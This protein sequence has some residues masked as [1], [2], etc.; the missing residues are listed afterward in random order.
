MANR[1]VPGTG[2][3]LAVAIETNG[4]SVGDDGAAQLA[5][6]ASGNV[7][8]VWNLTTSTSTSVWAN[9]FV[10]GTGWGTA[11]QIGSGN[12][13]S[14]GVNAQVGVDAAGNGFAV[15]QQYNG[16][17][18]NIWGNQFVAGTG[19][20][21]AALIQ[22]D[23]TLSS[24]DPRVAL[25]STGHAMVVWAQF[26]LVTSKDHIWASYFSAGSGWG[27][28]TLLQASNPT[29]QSNLP[30]IAFDPAGN[31]IA[32]W[33]QSLFSNSSVYAA[34]FVPGSGWSAE[35]LVETHISGS[36]AA[37]ASLG[38]DALGNAIVVWQQADSSAFSDIWAARF[39]AGTGW[40]TPTQIE[41]A[42]L[43]TGQVNQ[44]RIA[45]NAAGRAIV[46]WS[47]RNP[48]RFDIWANTYK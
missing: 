39:S 13:N 33:N 20:G 26:D 45:V 35:G 16:S 42:N 22:S 6:D 18:T 31:A 21:T 4:P 7:L 10:P 27:S 28:S 25:D 9:R 19:W 8:V 11:S 43:R 36:A 30:K 2:W 40:A 1:Y 3:G 34:R 44:A 29:H 14:S 17:I 12:P 15:W 38:I 5:I 41:P 46:V 32:V 24:R 23:P 48:T 37:N 47:R